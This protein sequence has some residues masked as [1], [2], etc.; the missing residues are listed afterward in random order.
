M[1]A[2]AEASEQKNSAIKEGNNVNLYVTLPGAVMA[3]TLLHLKSN[4]AKIAKNLKL[5]E[6]FYELD[7]IQPMDALLKC[8]GNNLIMWDKINCTPK[9]IDS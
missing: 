1:K 4:N 6:S 5:P 2:P 8:L 9:W 7:S 3:L